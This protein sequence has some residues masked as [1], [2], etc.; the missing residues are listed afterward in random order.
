MALWD[1]FSEVS[2]KLNC[3]RFSS[4][5]PFK[6]FSQHMA[7]GV[8]ISTWMVFSAFTWLFADFFYSIWMVFSAFTWL[9]RRLVCH[10]HLRLLNFQHHIKIQ[11]LKLSVN[12]SKI[13]EHGQSLRF[14]LEWNLPELEVTGY[15]APS[16]DP[17]PNRCL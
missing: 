14:I 9:I 17:P 2:A 15:S 11:A 5:S 7:F 13:K 8:F 6:W 1:Y 3:E 16:S 4:E 10:F 12:V